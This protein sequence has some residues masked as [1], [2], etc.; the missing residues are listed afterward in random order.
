MKLLWLIQFVG[1]AVAMLAAWWW[2]GLPD[3]T[4]S[5]IAL[6][7]LAAIIIVGAYAWVQATL[8]SGQW[9]GALRRTPLVALWLVAL[10]AALWGESTALRSASQWLRDAV[11]AV[12][13]LLLI[14]VAARLASRGAALARVFR[15]RRYYG[16]FLLAMLAGVCLPDRLLSWVPQVEGLRN[17]AISFGVRLLA[18]YTL[19]VTSWVALAAAVAR[20]ARAAAPHRSVTAAT[21]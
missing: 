16:A 4:L 8:L 15:D 17:E 11:Y 9:K 1:N 3:A 12:T 21:P 2:L 6:S 7:V 13:F 10:G 14:P 19:A 20:I 18:A 5:Q